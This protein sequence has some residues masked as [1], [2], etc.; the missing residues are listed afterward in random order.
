MKIPPYW[1]KAE[2]HGDNPKARGSGV[3]A[4]GW[5]F[6]SLDEARA[7]ALQ[8]ARRIFDLLARGQALHTYEYS[9]RPIREEIIQEMKD[10][11]RQVALITRNRYGALVLNSANVLFADVDHAA[12]TGGGLLE[13]L[14]C[15]VLPKKREARRQAQALAATQDIERW[16]RDNPARSF[17]LYR[18][19]QGLR[20]LFTDKLYDPTSDETLTLLQSLHS[21]PMYIKLTRKQECFRAR[22]TAKPWRCG[23]A[24]PPNAYPWDSPDAER[25]F[26]QWE[27]QYAAADAKFRACEFV[28]AFGPMADIPA[29]QAV[30]AVHDQGARITASAPL[31]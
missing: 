1:S 18:T 30:T 31:A 4:R 25:A 27:K 16:A 5:S 19:Q 3:V 7:Q 8:R 15:L 9:D 20:L 10:G 14:L 23:C 2:Y 24:K 26:R 12:A 22:L 28:R 17:R 13:R 29:V 11:D 21:D 6:A